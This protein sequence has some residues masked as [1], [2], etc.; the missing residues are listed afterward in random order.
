MRP[1]DLLSTVALPGVLFRRLMESIIWLFTH[2]PR[3]PAQDYFITLSVFSIACL[4]GHL[5]NFREFSNLLHPCIYRSIGAFT[6]V[7]LGVTRF[8]SSGVCGS[9]ETMIFCII[10][11]LKHSCRDW[12]LALDIPGYLE[13]MRREQP[14]KR[15]YEH[16]LAYENFYFS[17]FFANSTTSLD[18]LPSCHTCFRHAI[19]LGESPSCCAQN[20]EQ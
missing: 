17:N 10:G 2:E 7:G 15:S 13:K 16:F 3:F 14:Q 12:Y 5:Q 9:P 6:S 1:F 19:F 8:S 11:Q 4:N 20:P 18:E